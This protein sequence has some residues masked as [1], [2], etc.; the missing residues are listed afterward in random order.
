M[1]KWK[2]SFY[3]FLYPLYNTCFVFLIGLCVNESTKK[4]HLQKMK[5][6]QYVSFKMAYRNAVCRDN[7]KK[8]FV[9]KRNPSEVISLINSLHWKINNIGHEMIKYILKDVKDG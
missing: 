4:L 3:L 5:G 6:Y 2:Y 7:I 8:I 1:S 9:M